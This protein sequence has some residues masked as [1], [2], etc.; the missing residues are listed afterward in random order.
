MEEARVGAQSTALPR[1]GV[2]LVPVQEGSRIDSVEPDSAAAEST[3]MRRGDVITSVNGFRVYNVPQLRW[4]IAH[5]KVE[6]RDEDGD[7]E[8]YKLHIHYRGWRTAEDGTVRAVRKHVTVYLAPVYG[9]AG[10]EPQEEPSGKVAEPERDPE[11]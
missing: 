10:G 9:G 8:R 6:R 1:L 2:A 5:S 4:V 7:T 11:S 3:K